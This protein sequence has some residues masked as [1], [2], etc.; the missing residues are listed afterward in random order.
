MPKPLVDLVLVL[1]VATAAKAWGVT[2]DE[3]DTEIIW[4]PKSQ[5]KRGDVIKL[6]GNYDA[7]AFTMPEWLATEKGLV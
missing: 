5:A 7:Y 6:R 1:R 4:L 3:D 2:E